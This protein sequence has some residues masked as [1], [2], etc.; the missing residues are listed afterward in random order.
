MIIQQQLARKIA[1]TCLNCNCNKG[2]KYVPLLYFCWVVFMRDTMRQE[3]HMAYVYYPY[4]A[5]T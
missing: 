5:L 2:K 1:R 3:I 4:L